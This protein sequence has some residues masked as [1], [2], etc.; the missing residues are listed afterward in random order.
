MKQNNSSLSRILALCLRHLY[1]Y[2]NSKVRLIEIA[3]WPTLEMIVWG[4]VT[5]YLI[6]HDSTNVGAFG[7]FIAGALLWNVTIRSQLGYN[8]LF[9]EE[10]WSR[11][12]GHL[13]VSPLRPFE[14]VLSL[15]TMSFA[16]TVVGVM[17]AMIL[18]IYFYDFSVFSLGIA[19]IVF[20]ISLMITGWWLGLFMQ[21]LILRLG[22]GAEALAWTVAFT[23]SPIS[24]VFYPV[25]ILPAWLQPISLSIPPTYCFEGMRAILHDQSIDWHAMGISFGLNALYM[26]LGG[27]AFIWAFNDARRRGALLGGGE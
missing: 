5:L 6:N 26:I 15:F 24:A 21:A 4:F 20:F 27:L 13:F 12:L 17:P 3:Y 7:A 1:L 2:K 9:L 18:A 22:L 25:D 23:L 14:W 11:N 16:R 10:M 8:F 19:F